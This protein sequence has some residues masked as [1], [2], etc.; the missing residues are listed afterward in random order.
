M[1][2]KQNALFIAYI[3]AL[4]L[5][6]IYR[7][8]CLCFTQFQF[9]LWDRFVV[10]VTASTWVFSLADMIKTKSEIS[11]Y[12]DLK[13]DL[14]NEKTEYMM[15]KQ[16]RM[17]NE[18]LNE[19]DAGIDENETISKALGQAVE[20]NST[21]EAGTSDK[22]GY[23]LDII[24]FVIF[25]GVFIFDKLFE[26]LFQ[27]QDIITMIA[28]VIVLWTYK[29]KDRMLYL[30]NNKTHS[31]VEKQKRLQLVTTIIGVYHNKEKKKH[32]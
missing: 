3:I 27:V 9:P 29:Y 20:D 2:N 31:I 26:V 1:K 7:I 5:G 19:E 8:S 23:I 6:I 13:A 10:S 18:V 22:I 32:G 14:L 28:F 30:V 16:L 17:I 25:L 15:S 4:C 11:E 21:C 24:G 12:I